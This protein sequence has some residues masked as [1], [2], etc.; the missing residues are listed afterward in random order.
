MQRLGF[1]E[2]QNLKVVERGYAASIDQFAELAA[3]LAKAKVDAIFSV[4]DVAIRAA[5]RAT[6]TIPR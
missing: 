3:E 5:Q 6:A 4:G 2:G 1:I